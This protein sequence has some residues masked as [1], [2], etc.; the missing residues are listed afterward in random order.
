MTLLKKVVQIPGDVCVSL[1]FSLLGGNT[2]K[3]FGYILLHTHS[4]IY[5]KE[6][7]P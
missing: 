5:D 6:N 1:M 4:H 3:M 2:T 7:I